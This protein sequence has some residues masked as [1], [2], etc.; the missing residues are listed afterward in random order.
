MTILIIIIIL[1][2]FIGFVSFFCSLHRG[3]KATFVNIKANLPKHVDSFDM[4]VSKLF[5]DKNNFEDAYITVDKLKLHAYLFKQKAPNRPWV[6]IIHGYNGKAQT[7]SRQL[8]HFYLND[9]FN[10]LCVDLRSSGLSEGQFT[11]MSVLE[12][13]DIIGWINY[14][15]EHYNYPPIILYGESMGAATTMQ[16]CGEDLSDNVICAIE[17]CGFTS[18]F[19]EFKYQAKLL[20]HLPPFPFVYL[21][22]FYS[23]LLLG[24][25]FINDTPLKAI[26]KTKVPLLFIHGEDDTFVPFYM[27]DELIKYAKENDEILTIPEA[28]HIY[29]NI[30]D[31]DTYW[32]KVDSFIEKFLKK[33]N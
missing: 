19:E 10:C 27:H 12:K 26:S 20:F 28:G 1:I 14:L 5:D 9:H 13:R 33:G 25:D 22:N 6:I 32:N 4:P 18:A 15:N 16:T 3:S 11:T 23:K 31:P 30:I 7:M 29:S 24:A 2:L 8:E 21:M 17:D